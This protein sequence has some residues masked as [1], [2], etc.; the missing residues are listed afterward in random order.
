MKAQEIEDKLN[1]IE[2]QKREL[3]KQL[4][5]AEYDDRV[6]RLT[7]FMPVAILA[8][9]LF[10]MYN[11]TDGCGWGYEQYGDVHNWGFGAEYSSHKQWLENVSKIAADLKMEAGQ[12][13]EIFRE[14]VEIKDRHPR[15]MEVIRR[16]VGYRR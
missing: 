9:D 5:A 1:E 3:Q 11:H 10:C 16:M 2:N 14:L 6:A 8:H 12:L 4:E 15:A 7:P 13:E